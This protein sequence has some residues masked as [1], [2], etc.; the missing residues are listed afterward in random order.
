[1]LCRKT[2]RANSEQDWRAEVV[3]VTVIGGCKL[4]RVP[5]INMRG[6]EQDGERT[7]YIRSTNE[8]NTKKNKCDANPRNVT[9]REDMI[10]CSSCNGQESPAA[11]K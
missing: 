8:R 9:C 5:V 2:V 1:M 3:S 7:S 10:T 11:N 6:M 4:V